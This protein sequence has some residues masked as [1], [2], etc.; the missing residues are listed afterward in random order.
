MR[1]CTL[2]KEEKGIKEGFLGGMRVK[3]KQTFRGK[4]VLY[5]V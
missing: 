2:I 1:E 3:I 5:H 4:K